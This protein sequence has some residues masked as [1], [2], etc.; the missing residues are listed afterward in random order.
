MKPLCLT[1]WGGVE[2]GRLGTI[3]E[4]LNMRTQ[5]TA[6]RHGMIRERAEA[7]MAEAKAVSEMKNLKKLRSGSWTKHVS[8]VANRAKKRYLSKRYHICR[9]DCNA[10]WQSK[11]W[12]KLAILQKLS[13]LAS[14]ERK[15]PSNSQ[16]ARAC[17]CYPQPPS[18]KSSIWAPKRAVEGVAKHWEK[19]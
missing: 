12:T 19:D 3:G 14:T 11:V 15:K 13:L 6:Y 17:W 10:E 2:E 5:G 18:L 4:A 1:Q 7:D 9:F 16:G 8:R